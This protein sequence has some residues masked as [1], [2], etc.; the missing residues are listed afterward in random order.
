PVVLER[1]RADVEELVAERQP[2]GG[3]GGDAERDAQRHAQTFSGVTRA[4]AMAV[5]ASGTTRYQAQ[6]PRR[7]RASSP[8]STRILRWWLT[9]P[10]DSPRAAVRSQTQASPASAVETRW[11]SCTRAGSASAL[12]P[13]ATRTASSRSSGGALAEQQIGLSTSSSMSSP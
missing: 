7:S 5:S 3:D 2:D 10:W 4:P 12:N 1:A 13:A 6:V 8:A 11:I 9:V